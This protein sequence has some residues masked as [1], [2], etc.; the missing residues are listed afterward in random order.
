ME[1]HEKTIKV[2][3]TDINAA[4]ELYQEV[5]KPNELG[6]SPY[7]WQI[8]DEIIRPILI[9]NV[10]LKLGDI[11]KKYHAV[12]H[13]PIPAP[14]LSEGISQLEASNLIETK[15]DPDDKRRKIVYYVE[16]DTLRPNQ[17]QT[18]LEGYI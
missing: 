9:E 17:K 6:L 11:Q 16:P 2:T 15:Q 7:V 5:S 13:R 8:F 14:S 10:P 1:D 18:G 3:E 12:Y 4:F